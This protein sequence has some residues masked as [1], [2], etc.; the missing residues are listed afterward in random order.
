[1]SPVLLSDHMKHQ[2]SQLKIPMA[3]L[4]ST[5]FNTVPAGVRV[6]GL[7]SLANRLRYLNTMATSPWLF[8]SSSPRQP[9]YTLMSHVLLSGG[10]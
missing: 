3:C 9:R 10:Y 1:M 4:R 5:L 7:L 8:S 2:K 6:L